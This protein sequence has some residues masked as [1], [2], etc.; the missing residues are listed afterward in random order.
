MF[1]TAENEDDLDLR[2]YGL[3]L[4]ESIVILLGGCHKT[5]NLPRECINCRTPFIQANKFSSQLT[6]Q[7]KKFKL[8]FKKIDSFKNIKFST[9]N[10]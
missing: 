6:K 8:Q 3:W 4:S 5:H 1:D 10:E 7:E 2:L 9:K